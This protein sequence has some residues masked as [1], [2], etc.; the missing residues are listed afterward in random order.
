MHRLVWILAGHGAARITG[1]DTLEVIHMQN[2]SFLE[3]MLQF[4]MMYLSGIMF[5]A[6]QAGVSISLT[7][8]GNFI[9]LWG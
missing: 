6:Y 4:L 9:W 5:I 2:K 8:A 7:H 3:N 1:F